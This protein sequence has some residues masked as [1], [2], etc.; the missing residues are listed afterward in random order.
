MYH[1]ISTQSSIAFP[2]YHLTRGI[3]PLIVAPSHHTPPTTFIHTTTL[4]RSLIRNRRHIL[5]L[6][7][8]LDRPGLP[9]H[10]RLSLQLHRLATALRLLAGRRIRLDAAQEIVARAGQLDVLDAHVDALF[11][12]AVADLAHQDHADGGLGH[13]VDDAGFAVVHF[14]GHTVVVLLVIWC[15][16]IC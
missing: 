14:V 13:V 6:V 10:H 11:H 4:N 2:F 12:V 7:I 5:R 3:I 15:A 9:W 16:W 8:H 1:G